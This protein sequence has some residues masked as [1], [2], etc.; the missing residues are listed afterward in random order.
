MKIT[1]VGLGSGSMDSLSLGAYKRIT[2]SENIYLRTKKHPICEELDSLGIKYT[3]FDDIYNAGQNFEEVYQ[4]LVDSLIKSAREKGEILYG[5][6]GHPKVAETSVEW[7]LASEFVQSGEIEI[8]IISSNSFLDDTFVFLDVDPVKNGFIFLDALEFDL[9]ALSV[10]ADLVFTQVYSGYIASELKLKLLEVLGD[11]VEVILFKA[12]GIKG[13]EQKQSVKLHEIDRCGFE[14]DHLT[15]LYIPYKKENKKFHSLK[16]LID[17]LAYLR[18]D[19]GCPWDK[20]QDSFSI[21]KNIKEEV[22]ELGLAIDNQD[23][24][25][26]V[27]ELGD[28]LMLLVMQAQFGA[29]EGFFNMDDVIDGIVKKLIFRHPHIFGDEKVYSLDE[30][31]EIWEKQKTKEKPQ[32]P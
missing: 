7:L 12:A 3:A 24:D 4:A 5:V 9:S 10:E 18:G 22:H 29:E 25:N 8:E 23:I 17:L 6:P 21:M 2:K 11:E 30:A 1:V 16:D 20:K 13:L 19:N 32:K 15:S 28:V 27:E 31:N 14:F 26:T